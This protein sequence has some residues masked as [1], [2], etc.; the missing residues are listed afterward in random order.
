MSVKG[1]FAD[2]RVKLCI[3]KA[4]V[5]RAGLVK[6]KPVHV[7]HL[8]TQV[9]P[10]ILKS[11]LS[12]REP[13]NS[14]LPLCSARTCPTQ[15]AR[16]Y[17]GLVEA[18]F[19]SASRSLLG[20]GRCH[21]GN[22]VLRRIADLALPDYLQ[23]RL[24]RA[25]AV[26]GKQGR[27]ASSVHRSRDTRSRVTRFCSFSLRYGGRSPFQLAGATSRSVSVAQILR[28]S[29]WCGEKLGRAAE[30][31]FRRIATL[32]AIYRQFPQSGVNAH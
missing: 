7:R 32:Q 14:I 3:P 9:I 18:V 26:E 20:G 22:T 27:L 29:H 21:C 4:S 15:R 28:P 17:R 11:S 10:A 12:T 25:Q 6:R 16:A 8:P 5:E 1:S 2:Y 23:N 31:P 13:S 19:E 24:G 30:L